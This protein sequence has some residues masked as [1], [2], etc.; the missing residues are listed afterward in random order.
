MLVGYVSDENYS[1]LAD[2]QIVFETPA[3]LISTRSLANGAVVAEIPSGTCRAI[4]SHPG[5]GRKT[6]D[7][8]ADPRQP[9][10]FRLIAD[11]LLGY[12][13][14]KWRR[15]GEMSE[16][17]VHSTTPYH[18]SLWRY[19]WEKELIR[20]LGW[21]DDHGP[22]TTVQIVPDGDFTQTGVR[23]NGDL[24]RSPWHPQRIAAPERSGLYFFHARNAGGEFFTFPWII[25]PIQPRSR[26][27]VL[28][29][30]MTWNAY[31]AFGGRSN[32]VNQRELLPRPTVHARQDLERYRF[33]GT[34]PFEIQGAPLSFDRPEPFNHISE[35]AQITDPI[36]HRLSGAMAPGEWRLLGWLEREGFAHDLYSEVDLHFGRVPLEQY[37]VL[38]LNN[39]PEYVTREIY[40]RIKDWV[41]H[42]GKLMYLGGCGFLCELEF[43][44]EFT[45]TCRQEEKQDLRG[46]P[47]ACLLGLDYSHGG[48]QSGA[49]YR[50]LQ[51]D[52]WAFAGTGLGAGDL[53]GLSSLH[54]RC[55]GGASGHELDKISANSPQNLEHLAK[56][57][58]P[59]NSGA[60]LVCYQTPG[61]GA[62]FSV[63]SLCWTLSLPIDQ[64]IS[65]I[66]SNVLRRFLES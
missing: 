42:G 6:V 2:V 31:N 15:A 27:A 24:Y 56:G 28:T 19:G 30:N 53:F 51:P 58:N 13:W 38:I 8:T 43:L 22:R 33:P 9:H 10:Q 26:I 37:D 45:V 59:D 17:R 54:E 65:Q 50:V 66:T 41:Q 23:W 46:E 36:H 3:G 18:L 21:F 20:K 44:D 62:V 55:P 49:P 25:S 61:G 64:G 16:F 39:H 7:F 60:D 57:T 1:A 63:G 52:H 48:Y 12:V 40:F 14:P 29:A 34:W 11:G 5:F 35:H 32:Y 4:L 47:A